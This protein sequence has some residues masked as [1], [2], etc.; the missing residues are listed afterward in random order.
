[1]KK[2]VLFLLLLPL[3]L[4]AQNINIHSFEVE[5][6]G[7]SVSF[8]WIVSDANLKRKELVYV[9][10][11]SHDRLNYHNISTI[12]GKKGE[13]KISMFSEFCY[14][15]LKIFY[16]KDCYVLSGEEYV[17]VD[18]KI[19]VFPDPHGTKT[20]YVNSPEDG[21]AF[22]FQEN[23]QVFQQEIK[24]GHNTL[25]HNLERGEYS[26]QIICDA[27]YQEVLFFVW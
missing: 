6:K 8:L 11:G 7:S 24:K 26:I 25:E 22:I 21:M 15:R 5:R 10:Q 19:T 3:W 18:N 27:F 13:H 20:V 16:Q 12:K 23:K 4:N 9:L 2:I 17:R 1:M 14:F